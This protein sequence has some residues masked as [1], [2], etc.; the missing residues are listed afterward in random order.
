MVR[1]NL[2][3]MK[4]FELTIL[5]HVTNMEKR[6]NCSSKAAALTGLNSKRALPTILEHTHKHSTSGK[7]GKYKNE[8]NPFLIVCVHK[9]RT[10]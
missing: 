5:G 2:C 3:T 7:I 9:L 10:H 1:A 4:N 8:R 6:E